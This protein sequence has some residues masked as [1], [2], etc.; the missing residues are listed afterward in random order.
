[1][2]GSQPA[3]LPTSSTRCPDRSAGTRSPRPIQRS[4]LR[5]APPTIRS[6]RGGTDP[7]ATAAAPRRA[8][9]ARRARSATARSGSSGEKRGSVE[10]S[11]SGGGGR[12][13]PSWRCTA[14]LT[15]ARPSATPGAS[16]EWLMWTGRPGRIAI[17]RG[18][19][20]SECRARGSTGAAGARKP[21]SV[22]GR[23]AQVGGLP[24]I[25]GQELVTADRV[26]GRVQRQAARTVVGED[27]AGGVALRNRCPRPVNGKMPTLRRPT[28]GAPP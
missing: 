17:P 8:P 22:G 9:T 13:S 14:R 3:L 20:P 2:K 23:S 15:S 1:M 19:A 21:S 11:T 24:G 7:E 25:G 10:G 28:A 27:V 16:P 12:S 6:P 18:S 26:E 4:S 5:H